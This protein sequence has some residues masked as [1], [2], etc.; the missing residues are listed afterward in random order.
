MDKQYKSLADFV[1]YFYNEGACRE[2]FE[3]IKSANGETCQ[4]CGNHK[5]YR[6]DKGKCFTIKTKTIFGG[7][8][9]PLQKWY[10]AI[11]LLTTSTKS[12]LS[13][14]FAKHIG[15]TQKTARHMYKRFRE[16]MKSQK[17]QLF[18]GMDLDETYI[19][20]KE[21]NKHFGKRTKGTQGSNTKTKTTIMGLIELKGNVVA[22]VVP[23]VRMRTIEKH[24]VEY[25]GIGTQL[26]T[27][28]FTFYSK[29][30]DLY[31]HKQIV[32]SIESFLSVVI[33]EHIII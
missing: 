15:V 16:V 5:I 27:D 30:K 20:G 2:Y 26:Y 28:E 17:R 3:T 13:K 23:N 25:V 6:Y 33:M 10:I 22:K 8:K 29:I 32:H 11:Y 1:F 12:I 21:N 7:S 19:C 14:Q 4:H 18:G 9:I 24:I 31:P